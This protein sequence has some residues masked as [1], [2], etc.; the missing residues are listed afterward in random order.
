MFLLM[1]YKFS[2][3]NL[4][5]NQDYFDI[6]FFNTIINLKETKAFILKSIN[7]IYIIKNIKKLKS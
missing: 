3:K 2:I 5:E 6:K 1:L 7:F 4:I